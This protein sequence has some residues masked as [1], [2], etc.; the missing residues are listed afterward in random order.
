MTTSIVRV[1]GSTDKGPSYRSYYGE[2]LDPIIDTSPDRTII[3]LESINC[4]VES[5]IEWFL[6]IEECKGRYDFVSDGVNLIDIGGS[7]ME[8][9]KGTILMISF[10]DYF[11]ALI[12]NRIEQA[13]RDLDV[14]IDK[15]KLNLSLNDKTEPSSTPICEFYCEI[16]F[17]NNET[18]G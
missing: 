16:P 14:L 2:D 11:S 10:E 3:E 7:A 6:T 12:E 4:S 13:R 18:K 8:L 1:L 15:C 9:S 5:F 17:R